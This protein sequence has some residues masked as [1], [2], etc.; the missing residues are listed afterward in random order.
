MYFFFYFQDLSEL[1]F[2]S[3]KAAL[4]YDGVHLFS[5]AVEKLISDTDLTTPQVSCDNKDSPYLLGEPLLKEINSVSPPKSLGPRSEKFSSHHH[6]FSRLRLKLA[7]YCKTVQ[8]NTINL[9]DFPCFSKNILILK[10]KSWARG[11][12]KI[13][14]LPQTLLNS[15]IRDLSPKCFKKYL[16]YWNTFI[17]SKIT[18]YVAN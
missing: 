10:T 8:K 11:N 15:Q 2:R 14:N 1:V 12:R 18:F 7:F 6:H 9:K 17:K 16:I 5:R 4:L 13:L 3:H